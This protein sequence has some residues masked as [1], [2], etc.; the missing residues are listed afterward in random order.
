M[1]PQQR[2]AVVVGAGAVVVA[3][4]VVGAATGG[5][6]SLEERHYGSFKLRLGGDGVTISPMPTPSPGPSESPGAGGGLGI[7]G[8]W[9]LL[10]LAAVA[11]AAT[12]LALWRLWLRF[13]G[14]A[15]ARRPDDAQGRGG[16]A[17]GERE[18]ELEPLATAAA[19]AR[20]SLAGRLD[21]DDAIIAAWLAVERGA[22]ASGVERHRAQTATEFTVAVLRRTAADPSAIASL[23]DL[24]H[25]ARFSPRTS[26]RED[27]QEAARC[28]EVL[29]RA[30]SPAPAGGEGVSS[31]TSP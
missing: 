29:A 27:L 21:A 18:P 5:G 22:A 24:Y 31:G 8:R 2:P 16:V 12:A 7:E 6:W 9:V 30:W 20:E 11:L 26:S 14:T 25:R 15:A 1:R 4:A 13:R 19:A 23:R 17:A 10:A 28:I 3:L